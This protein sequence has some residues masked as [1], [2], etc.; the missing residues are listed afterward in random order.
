[1]R[2]NT[3][4]V[5]PYCFAYPTRPHCC[6]VTANRRSFAGTKKSL[7][8]EESELLTK[9]S[10]YTRDPVNDSQLRLIALLFLIFSKSKRRKS[11]VAFGAPWGLDNV[12]RIARPA[13]A[14][15]SCLMLDRMARWRGGTIQR[16]QT[17]R[18][19]AFSLRRFAAVGGEQ[20][21]PALPLLRAEPSE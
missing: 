10:V 9:P 17:V 18:E 8:G 19:R 13:S 12:D 16:D 11:V 14:S 7:V 6:R 20:G 21:K 15:G 4:V 5:R 1:M 3:T 2:D